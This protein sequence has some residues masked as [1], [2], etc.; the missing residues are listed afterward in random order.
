MIHKTPW[1]LG[2]ITMITGEKLDSQEA[3][4][5]SGV[6]NAQ[7]RGRQAWGG[8]DI[9]AGETRATGVFAS[10]HVFQILAVL[11]RAAFSRRCDCEV[12]RLQKG[13]KGC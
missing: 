7:W 9:D 2:L 6:P 5:A 8:W 10:P 1:K 11:T 4:P 12:F 13:K 3:G